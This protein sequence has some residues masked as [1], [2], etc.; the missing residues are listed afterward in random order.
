MF[1]SAPHF[2]SE[3]NFP[4]LLSFHRIVVFQSAPH[5][6]SEA[7]AR[8][9]Q[10]CGTPARFNPR[11]T[12]AARRTLARWLRDWC[13]TCFNPRLTS[14]AR[15]TCLKKFRQDPQSVS[16]R[17]SLQQRG[18]QSQVS[19]KLWED[20]FQSAP[21]FS[22]EANAVKL[23]AKLG[24]AIVSIRASLQQRGEHFLSSQSQLS[25]A[26]QSAPHFS[27]E[28]NLKYSPLL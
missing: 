6:S 23:I 18:E 22:S 20:K 25:T 9:R 15:R 11:L 4:L 21:H 2:S 12:S 1:Q 8:T 13:K 28:A 26:F 24:D 17:A 3:A 10:N 14:A 7:N 19:V 16:I 27:S 5:F